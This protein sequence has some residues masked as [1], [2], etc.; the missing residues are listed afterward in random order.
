MSNSSG[1]R[2]IIF[3][4]GKIC[5]K[6]IAGILLF[7]LVL[8]LL[9]QTS[10]VQ[11]FARKKI[12]S[13][14][15]AKLHTKVS[16][17]DLDIGFPKKIILK[18]IYV[19]DLQ[20]D[21]LLSGERLEINISMF[22]LLQ[23]TVDIR[24]IGLKGITVKIKRVLPD[25]SFN[26]DFIIKAFGSNSNSDTLKKNASRP[27]KIE[28]DRIYLQRIGGTYKDDAT[29][30]DFT[31]FLEDFS[32]RI[33]TFDPV[34]L[35]FSAG[36]ISLSGLRGNMRE[37]QPVLIIMKILDILEIHILLSQPVFF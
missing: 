9:I 4:V 34:H 35:V 31:A 15:Q 37:Y 10:F 17:G 6:V 29:G 7:I 19:E 16:I 23:H 14:L 18:N 28:L 8:L 20:K 30:N 32:T 13:Y 27:F 2:K 36:D 21:T 22:R 5:L 11:N 24:E 26:Y 1:A 33:K 25:S 3:R 12:V